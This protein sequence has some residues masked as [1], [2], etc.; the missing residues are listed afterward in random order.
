M[1]NKDGAHLMFRNIDSPAREPHNQSHQRP[2]ML[3]ALLIPVL[4]ST[5]LASSSVPAPSTSNAPLISLQANS[6][7]GYV[8]DDRR[9]PIPDLQV[10]L[11]N[12]VDSVI[13]RTRTNNSGL[14]GFRRL[15]TGAFQIRVQPYGST[16]VGQTQ[17]VLLEQTRAFE[18]VDFVLT[19]R[20]TGS[21]TAV[22]RVVFVQE[23]P[24]DAK[25]Q[26]ER[27][28][29]LLAKEQRNEAI[30]SLEKAVEIFPDY[31]D[32]LQLLGTEYVKDKEYERA[33]PL[34]TKAAEV[35]RQ[36]HQSLYSLSVAQYNLKQIPEAVESM[37]RAIVL[38][39]KSPTANLWL[40]M[41]LRQSGKLDEAEPYLKDADRLAESKS[42]DAHWQLA[43]LYNQLKRYTEAAD[44]LEVFLKVQPDSKDKE[45]IQKL[46]KRLRQLSAE[47]AK[48]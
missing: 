23:V 1:S 25:K 44:H 30:A 39:H 11:L 4:V 27:G 18:Q 12:D 43:L 41:L 47:P 10:E 19:K 37:R 15:T 24:E 28:S 46:I 42:P 13:Q 48:Q 14:Y 17:R 45:M 40:G 8:Y 22:G 16:Y 9:N 29:E 5:L 21:A 6:I 7:T 20:S 35:N 26:Y 36:A 34:L 32:A 3:S 38:N 31:F 33:V 2:M